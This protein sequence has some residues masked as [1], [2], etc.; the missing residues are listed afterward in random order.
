MARALLSLEKIH[1]L[2]RDRKF[3]VA[4]DELDRQISA[5]AG[6]ESASHTLPQ[7]LVLRGMIRFKL[8]NPKGALSDYDEAIAL[9]SAFWPAYFHRW[10]CNL[11]LG[12]RSEANADREEGRKLAPQQFERDYDPHP[13]G[14]I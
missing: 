13:A 2:L 12:N 5:H 11:E 6:S 9:D 3:S 1:G 14:M 8:H 10:Q 4:L 7:L